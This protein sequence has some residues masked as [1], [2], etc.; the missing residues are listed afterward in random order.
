M[1]KV[2]SAR[3]PCWNDLAH[4]TL[5]LYVTFE[6]SRESLGEIIFTASPDDPELHGRELFDRAVALEFGDI[7][8]PGVDVIK[9][10]MLLQRAELTAVA[11]SMIE[12]LQADVNILQ[13]SVELEIATDKEIAALATKKISLSTWKKYRVLLSRVQEQE[14]FPTVIEWPEIPAE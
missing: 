6:E 1:M 3:T 11:N 12:K 8:E 5:N 9:S 13:D 10:N 4:T 7:A 14:G 2:L